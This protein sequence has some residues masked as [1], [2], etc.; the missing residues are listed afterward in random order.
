VAYCAVHLARPRS[1]TNSKS[2]S[3]VAMLFCFHCVCHH[4]RSVRVMRE[5][6]T[7][8]ASIAQILAR[9]S[10]V[11]G[12]LSQ[13]LCGGSG[14]AASRLHLAFCCNALDA[15]M[16][17]VAVF[18]DCHGSWR[19]RF[20]TNKEKPSK[21]SRMSRIAEGRAAHEHLW[22]RSWLCMHTARATAARR[23]MVASRLGRRTDVPRLACSPL[24][25]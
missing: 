9:S 2:R 7:W 6:C 14:S 16:R 10:I 4:S 13:A 11:L 22:P 15:A 8:L 12:R 3:L 1:W 20:T 17:T 19:G 5:S 18:S 21:S 25:C 23:T 24:F